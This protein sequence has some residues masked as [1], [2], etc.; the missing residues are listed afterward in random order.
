MTC[1]G[2]I[3]VRDLKHSMACDRL[4]QGSYTA[5]NVAAALPESM[6]PKLAGRLS[7]K[8]RRNKRM[9]SLKHQCTK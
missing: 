6:T 7:A 9:V 2:T 5:V 8:Q 1:K 4:A 3:A